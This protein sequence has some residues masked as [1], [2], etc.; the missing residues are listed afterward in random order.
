MKIL[1]I[2]MLSLFCFAACTPAVRVKKSEAAPGFALS[3][4]ETFNFYEVTAE[5]SGSDASFNTRIGIIKNAI[6]QEL[7]AKGLTLDT[8]NPDLLVNIGVVSSEKVQT[9]ETTIR[10][11][12][13]YIGQRRYSWKSQ[14]VEVGRY[15]EGTVTVDLVDREKNT[16]VWEGAAS[17]IIPRQDDQLQKT[18]AK[19]IAKLLEKI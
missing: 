3:Q 12:P 16:L 18:A 9:R 8:S 5:P 7:T 15:R 1:K 2:L 17:A 4:Y 11:A 13:R 6:Q 10:E 14:E 19:G